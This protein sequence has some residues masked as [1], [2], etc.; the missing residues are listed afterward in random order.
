MFCEKCGAQI[1]VGAR[2]CTQCGAPVQ[3]E[4]IA[5]IP[6]VEPIRP[7]E[8]VDPI[9]PISEGTQTA[10]ATAQEPETPGSET[11][12]REP[13][14]SVEETA[15]REQKVAPEATAAQD[16][17]EDII[18]S[19]P[20][21]SV[22]DGL[23]EDMSVSEI[24][25]MTVAEAETIPQETQGHQSRCQN[26]PYA[27]NWEQ[28]VA[29]YK[30]KFN[31]FSLIVC[32]I[33]GISTYLPILSLTN[34]ANISDMISAADIGY[35]PDFNF[36]DI[37]KLCFDLAYLGGEDVIL[38]GIVFILAAGLVILNALLGV[39]FALCKKKA[40]IIVFGVFSVLLSIVYIMF[41]LIMI[42]EV[43]A[44]AGSMLGLGWGLWVMLA[45]SILYMVSG[46]VY[47]TKSKN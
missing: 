5:P 6:V 2:F 10:E 20:E 1:R 39:I 12:A 3:L 29:K 9:E 24:P 21:V 28:P 46:I 41:M 7:G 30:R 32:I 35:G 11:T 27:D 13:E 37:I 22:E 31:I 15:V 16:S 25:E 17:I 26:N 38:V 4:P 43:T 42:N 47:R 8:P 19:I 36:F 23:S 40:P 18:D 33:Y 34:A 14:P 44:C 45:A